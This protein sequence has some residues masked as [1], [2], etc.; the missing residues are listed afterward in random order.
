MQVSK[1]KL[2]I[3]QKD[4]LK[5]LVFNTMFYSVGLRHMFTSKKSSSD[6]SNRGTSY[7]ICACK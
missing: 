2:R 4:F 3:F 5:G 1:N 6:C 7:G